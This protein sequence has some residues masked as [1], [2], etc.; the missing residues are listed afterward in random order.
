LGVFP[1][2]IRSSMTAVEVS[3]F[4]F[5]SWW[6]SCCVRVRAGR[7]A[8]TRTQAR[9]SPRCEGK[10]RDCHCSHWAPDDGRENAQN[11]LSYK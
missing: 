6:Q 10:T 8:R 3:G 4:T 5:A 9:L 7:P 1:P 2:I 11:V